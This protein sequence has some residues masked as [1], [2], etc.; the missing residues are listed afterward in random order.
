M[1]DTVSETK[2]INKNLTLR[3]YML[4]NA[5]LSGVYFIFIIKA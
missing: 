3:Y 1:V 4:H 2:Q 5:P